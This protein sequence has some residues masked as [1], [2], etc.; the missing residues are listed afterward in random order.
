MSSN[1]ILGDW[2]SIKK[3]ILSIQTDQLLIVVDQNIPNLNLDFLSTYPIFRVRGGEEC[4]DFLHFEKA[5]T[6]FLERKA[7]RGSHLIVIG[8]GSTSDLAGFVAS[9][10][11][12]GISW[13]VVPTT[14]LSM[15]DASIGGKTAINNTFGKNL[16]GSFH[17]PDNIWLS[18]HF[19]NTLPALEIKSGLGEIFKYCLMSQGIE[20]MLLSDGISDE[21]IL[22]CAKFKNKIVNEDYNEKG[23]R[24][25]LNLGHT[26]GHAIERLTGLPHGIAV[27]L[28]TF[29]IIEL[30]S[31]NKVKEKSLAILRAMDIDLAVFDLGQL[32]SQDIFNL[33]SQD[34]KRLNH[35]IIEVIVPHENNTV[36]IDKVEL[37]SLSRNLMALEKKGF[38]VITE[39]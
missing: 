23:K 38:H 15:V 25:I 33:V 8:G 31:V 27:I 13:S 6:F 5:L 37:K 34:K 12:R 28:G 4:K 30:Y 36:T 32:K 26:I 17:L 11:N 39:C 24:K 16:I 3:K 2:D 22:K 9:S 18:R 20:Q 19:L 21:L 35:D 10:L 7:Y 29:F 14:L 1:I